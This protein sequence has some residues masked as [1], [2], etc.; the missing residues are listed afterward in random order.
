MKRLIGLLVLTASTVN[1]AGFLPA[2]VTKAN[3]AP[4][5]IDVRTRTAQ[6]IAARSAA[7][8]YYASVDMDGASWAE[9]KAIM[10]DLQA[11]GYDVDFGNDHHVYGWNK[12]NGALV[13]RWGGPKRWGPIFGK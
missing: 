2:T 10:K 8:Y 6:E 11:L 12:L 4:Q 7:G 13:I 1:A 9:E 5:L 3:Q